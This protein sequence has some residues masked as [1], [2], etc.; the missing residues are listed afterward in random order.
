MNPAVLKDDFG[1]I[2]V[3][4][5]VY[6]KTCTLANGY[7]VGGVVIDVFDDH[8]IVLPN[9]TPRQ[10]PD[11][12]RVDEDD[13]NNDDFVL[14]DRFYTRNAG[15]AATQLFAWLAAQSQKT[16]SGNSDWAHLAV[17][18]QSIRDSGLLT[19]RAEQRY[20]DYQEQLRRERAS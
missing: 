7:P 4:C 9:F 20:R 2:E 15:V 17:K 8:V 6:S 18:L 11:P 3:G 12:R 14:R 16:R 5:S 10:G 13:I 1:A 19:P